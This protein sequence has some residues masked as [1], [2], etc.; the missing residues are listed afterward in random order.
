MWFH[1]WTAFIEWFG[2]RDNVCPPTLQRLAAHET[3]YSLWWERNNRLHN[4]I[5]TPL[6]VTFKKIDRLVRNSIT[7]R[8]D[9]KKF[10]NLMSLWLKHEQSSS[11]FCSSL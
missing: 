1:T 5:S 10:R 7:A 3:I 8:K 6:Y 4:S 2:L 11:A 9:R